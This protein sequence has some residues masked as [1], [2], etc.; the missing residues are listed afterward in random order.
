[1]TTDGSLRSAA[2]ATRIAFI[3]NGLAFAS[4][5][6]IIPFAKANTGVDEAALGLLLLCLGIG[7]VISMP[8]TGWLCARH[9]TR[10]MILISALIMA[11]AL[12]F[13]AYLVEYWALAITLLIFGAAIGTLD[14]AM[15]IHA[16][17]VEKRSERA[18]MSGFHGMFSVGAICGAGFV[19]LMISYGVA[20]LIATLCVTG[21]V[22]IAIL[23]VQSHYLI[24]KSDA[25]EPFRPPSG[26]VKWL[27]LLA[28]IAFLIEGAIMDWGALLM[29]ER[30]V[31]SM[32]QAALGYI[33]FSITMVIGRL[34]GDYV[35]P[36]IGRR[37]IL[38]GGG[39]LV[40][41]GLIAITT[42]PSPTLNLIGFAVI[43]LGAA[44][45]VPVVFSAAGQQSDMDPNMAVASVTFV[46]YAGILLGPAI[47]GFG[48]QYTSLPLAMASLALLGAVYLISPVH[49]GNS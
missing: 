30:A 32:E 21:S 44:N 18:L 47:I 6:P 20:P 41:L 31:F 26:I 45:L 35:V 24:T 12:P 5:A 10:P 23:W 2:N 37:A 16:A 8:I 27:A 49:K 28:G 9:G 39:T 38:L 29:I 42:L 34:S 40:V 43:G 14:V 11:C 19:T 36:R 25:P 1:M 7:S 46:G 4:W 3:A 33:A 17:E 15:N 22:I 13:L 48:A